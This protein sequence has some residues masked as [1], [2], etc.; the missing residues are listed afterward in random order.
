MNYNGTLH[1][2]AG[3]RPAPEASGTGT[4]ATPR[5]KNRTEVDPPVP[6]KERAVPPTTCS[7]CNQPVSAWTR[8]VTTG[9]CPRCRAADERAGQAE[10]LEG[11]RQFEDGI[12][13]LMLRPM[14]ERWRK[15]LG[16]ALSGVRF[17]GSMKLVGGLIVGAVT[18]L[19]TLGFGMLTG[20][21]HASALVGLP[22]A[23]SMI[24]LMEITLGISFTDLAEQFDQEDIFMKFG[25][26][27][28]VLAFAAAYL[29]ACVFVYRRYFA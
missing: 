18:F 10:L 19:I 7:R 21:Y 5:G 14:P 6:D 26:A 4:Q 23:I 20:Y 13:R 2:L 17:R 1:F 27:V 9:L 24:G 25:I 16:H 11:L 28:V 3:P 15:G 29:A 22:L 12:L 8:D